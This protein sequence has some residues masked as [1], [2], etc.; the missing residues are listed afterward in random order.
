MC[1]SSMSVWLRMMRMTRTGR[2]CSFNPCWDWQRARSWQPGTGDAHR[3][4][5]R[6]D[7]IYI[8]LLHV[9]YTSVYCISLRFHSMLISSP[10]KRLAIAM[11]C[12]TDPVGIIRHPWSTLRSSWCI[13]Q[14]LM[15]WHVRT[16]KMQ[17]AWRWEYGT[18]VRKHMASG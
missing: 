3:F 16:C 5:F 15:F 6:Q 11:P 9:P 7:Q 4:W 2:R 18:G 14:L 1:C 17:S 8:D 10:N 13:L 12:D